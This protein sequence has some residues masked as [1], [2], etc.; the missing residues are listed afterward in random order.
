M[1]INTKIGL[2]GRYKLEV[3]NSSGESTRVI[4]WFDNLITDLGL[5]LL[6]GLCPGKGGNSLGAVIAPVCA[7]G[8]SATSPL[9][10]DTQLAALV[11]SVGSPSDSSFV[12]VPNRRFEYQVTYTFPVGAATGNLS[13]LGVGWNATSLFS[14]ALIKDGNGDPT[15]ITVLADESLRVTYEVWFNIP[16]GS[17]GDVVDGYTF[18]MKAANADG[19]GIPAPTDATMQTVSGLYL[20]TGAVGATIDD[21]PGGSQAAQL[22]L[23]SGAYTLGSHTLQATA[24][25]ALGIANA[26]L[27]AMMW[28]QGPIPWQSSIT[29]VIAK[30]DTKILDIT[31]ATSWAREGE[32]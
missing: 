25:A 2:Q 7:V 23:L 5:D 32:L 18:A 13:E 6:S 9:V 20:Y 22:T 19:A 29:P 17:F 15:T 3:L 26:D 21:Q 11:G 16:T 1:H 27:A 30:D 12:S 14:R 4:D 28:R 31:V 24:H 10:S 8:T